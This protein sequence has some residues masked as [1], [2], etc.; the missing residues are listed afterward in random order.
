LREKR[1]PRRRSIR[2][3]AY[4]YTQPGAYFV[5]ICTHRYEAIFGRIMGTEMELSAYGRIVAEEWTRTGDLR[6][7]VHLDT[8]VVMPNHMHGIIWLVN[9]MEETGL[10]DEDTVDVFSTA[11]PWASQRAHDGEQFAAPV[12]GSVPTVVR[13]FKSAV[14]RR[15][16]Q[17]RGT[18][19]HPVWH[20]SYYEHVIR[21]DDDLARIRRYIAQNCARWADDRF[22]R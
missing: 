10:A 19:G 18:P 15:I 4:D 21:D 8:Y 17:L 22:Y 20:R 9:T 6:A 12:A 13:A 5:T 2:L 7:N 1:F 3:R 11:C 14:T 16:N